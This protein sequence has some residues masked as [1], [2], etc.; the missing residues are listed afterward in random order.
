MPM[1]IARTLW[2]ETCSL[3]SRAGRFPSLAKFDL[4]RLLERLTQDATIHVATDW[5]TEK[6]QNGRREI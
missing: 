5:Q 6:R 4:G 2:V 3:S 1:Q